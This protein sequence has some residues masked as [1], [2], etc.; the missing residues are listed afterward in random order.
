VGQLVLKA[1]NTYESYKS[2]FWCVFFFFRCQP[3]RFPSLLVADSLLVPNS[4]PGTVCPA[5][6]I[7]REIGNYT[8]VRPQ[9]SP[10]PRAAGTRLGAIRLLPSQFGENR[11]VS[12]GLTSNNKKRIVYAEGSGYRQ[13][14]QTLTAECSVYSRI[15]CEGG[16]CG[17]FI[18]NPFQCA[19]G[20][21][22]QLNGIPDVGGVC[23]QPSAF[24]SYYVVGQFSRIAPAEVT[25]NGIKSIIVSILITFFF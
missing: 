11:T 13:I 17:G 15:S 4:K 7:A 18:R 20:L 3:L 6:K 12:I 10:Y 19:E 25:S 23:I 5:F 1:D 16:R 8:V 2:Y 9:S 21:R 22:C 14:K 24:E